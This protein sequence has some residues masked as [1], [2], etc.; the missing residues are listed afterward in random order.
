MENPPSPEKPARRS[1]KRVPRRNR[2]GTTSS[3]DVPRIEFIGDENATRGSMIFTW[4]GRL[5][6]LAMLLI[7]PWWIASVHQLPQVVLY[8]L[9]IGGMTMLW[10]AVALGKKARHPFP[11]LAFPVIAG[12]LLLVVQTVE[13]PDWARPV[14]APKQTEMY[15]AYADPVPRELLVEKENSGP[16]PVRI[17]MDLDATLK[18]INLLTLAL[19][20]VVLASY[21]FSARK[22]LAVLPLA[23]TINGVAISAYG[24]VQRLKEDNRIFG[25]IELDHKAT[26]FGPF[27]N[28]NNA[29]GY[30][31]ICLACSVGLIVMAFNRPMQSGQR[32]RTIITNDYPVW[33]RARLH[34]G[35]FLA[36]LNAVK[37]LTLLASAIIA[38][39]VVATLSRGGFLALVVA[40]AAVTLYY[41]MLKKSFFAIGAGAMLAIVVFIGIN[42]FGFGE[43][44]A[45]RLDRA[46]DTNFVSNEVRI[47]HWTQTSPAISEFFPLGSGVG[48]YH[49]VHR[50]YRVDSEDTIFYFAENQ[51]FQTLVEAG[52]GGLLLLLSAIGILVVCV[53]FLNSHGASAKTHSMCATGIFL[54][55]SQT[56]TSLFDFGH[57]IPANT[58]A[59]ALVSGMLVGQAHSLAGRLKKSTSLRY[60]MP[61]AFANLLLLL[62]FSAGILGGLGTFQYAQTERYVGKSPAGLSHATTD[63]ETVDQRIVDLKEVVDEN[64]EGE[65]CR[66]LG[67]LYILRYRLML[68]DKLKRRLPYEKV[69]DPNQAM[70]I[71]L[72]TAL[73]RLHL[74]VQT[75]WRANNLNRLRE[76][77]NDALVKTNLL[78]AIWYLKKSRSR[79]PLQPAVHLLLGQL[80][81]IGEQPDPDQPHLLR[82]QQLAPA[83]A[84]THLICGL[85]DLQANR[86]ESSCNNLR[87]CLQI[88]PGKYS[89]VIRAVAPSLS[90]ERIVSDIIPEDASML[91]EFANS[92]LL[93][94]SSQSLKTETFRRARNLLI[95]ENRDD[96]KSLELLAEIEIELGETGAATI[97]L[98]RLV[99]MNP[100]VRRLRINLI[101][102]LKDMGQYDE[103][104][105]EIRW[106]KGYG[107]ESEQLDTL[108]DKII[109]MRDSRLI[110]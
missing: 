64:P 44:I 1:S 70:G 50:L 8:C 99:D 98:R 12:L 55:V 63:L 48:S 41:S 3:G 62:I 100:D 56:I 76:V 87:K 20:C 86:I 22:A 5:L 51:Y 34:L 14:L 109:R 53:R 102:L 78:P 81:S 80:H 6:V 10:L 83:N 21:F 26:P 47:R 31:L 77:Q 84:I 52:W 4:I 7:S 107:D 97:T 29:A 82:A 24:V 33:Q 11:W 65:A 45:N 35:L 30:L 110:R 96:R 73:D 72:S 17:T 25:F 101:N 40:T 19:I 94:Q 74:I 23:A 59:M 108:R 36:E 28:Q 54:L 92:Y 106:M 2:A 89:L 61:S 95:D 15:A 66:R 37:L 90:A 105:D 71:W 57:F 38:A 69:A 79:S 85:M 58:I 88:D 91:Y 49:N 13:L 104:L 75:E 16:T 27:V 67:E 9:A 68:F 18:S 32:P 42:L 60:T 103:A 93:A 39:G 43:S 46:S